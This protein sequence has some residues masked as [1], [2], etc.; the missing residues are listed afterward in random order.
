MKYIILLISVLYFSSCDN[1]YQQLILRDQSSLK[2]RAVAWDS[3][4]GSILVKGEIFKD[5]TKG[6]KR[7]HVMF[8]VTCKVQDLYTLRF[9]DNDV[10]VMMNDEVLVLHKNTLTLIPIKK[11]KEYEIYALI[12][13]PK[14]KDIYVNEFELQLPNISL[15]NNEISIDS[16]VF[17]L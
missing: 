15:D 16:L 8:K 17:R 7:S 4:E 1:F 3:S 11:R 13:L 2:K 10:L 5:N 9:K 12:P 14:V 6:L